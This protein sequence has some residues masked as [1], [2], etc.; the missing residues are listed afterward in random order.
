MFGED[1]FESNW[2]DWPFFLVEVNVSFL[3]TMYHV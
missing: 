1:Y 2:K 3:C